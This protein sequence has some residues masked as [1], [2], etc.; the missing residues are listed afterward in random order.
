MLY[1]LGLHYNELIMTTVGSVRSLTVHTLYVRTLV[2]YGGPEYSLRMTFSK[3]RQEAPCYLV[4][5]DPAP[6]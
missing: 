3:A 4:F 5:E 6:S 1:S 2:S